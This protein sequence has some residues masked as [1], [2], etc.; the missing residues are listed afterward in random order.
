MHSTKHAASQSSIPLL[1]Y[2]QSPTS[3]HPQIICV[4]VLMP[5]FTPRFYPWLF[6][7]LLS[8]CQNHH[9]ASCSLLPFWWSILFGW[10]LRH[11]AVW[12]HFV[13]WNQHG[14][15]CCRGGISRCW[16]THISSTRKLHRPSAAQA[17]TPSNHYDPPYPPYPILLVNF[18]QS[19]S[20]ISSYASSTCLGL[21]AKHQFTFAGLFYLSDNLLQPMPSHDSFQSVSSIPFQIAVPR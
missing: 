3:S 16:F 13:F 2:H 12:F 9:I 17:T 10:E 8:N 18:L 15:S 5:R 4:Y 7:H 19:I 1:F 20:L 11:S 6:L 14:K 21:S